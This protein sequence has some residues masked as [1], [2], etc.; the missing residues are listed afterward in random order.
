MLFCL[1][2]GRYETKGEGYQKNNRIFNQQVT[3][4]EF[5][6]ANRNMPKFELPIAK[7][8]E[9]KDLSKD[10]QNSTSKQLGGYLKTLS[11]KDAWAESKMSDEWIKWVKA[12]PHF[13]A[14]IFNQITGLKLKDDV[15]LIGSEV[16][17]KFN[18]KSYKAK[19]I[20]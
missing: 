17:V 15:G 12:L 19:I 9:Y 4:D 14:E 20:E 3:P 13:S 7:W 16:E 1:G 11:Y 2:E 10:E 18:G 8:I 5:G 6:T